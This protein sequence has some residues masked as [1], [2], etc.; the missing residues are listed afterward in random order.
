MNLQDKLKFKDEEPCD[1]ITETSEETADTVKKPKRK[2]QKRF[3]PD[4]PPPD[5]EKSDDN[6]VAEH[7]SSKEI[8]KNDV[9]DN[10]IIIDRKSTRLNSSH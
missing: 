10:E 4:E 9:S 7:E 6:S 2:Q 1:E 3:T 8:P 5:M